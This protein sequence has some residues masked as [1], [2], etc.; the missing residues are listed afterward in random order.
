MSATKLQ[1]KPTEPYQQ[2]IDEVLAAHNTDPGLGFSPSSTRVR[3]SVVHSPDCSL[4]SGCG[5]RCAIV[6]VASG[7]N[8]RT[9]FAAS[10]FDGEFE[11][12]RL[13]A[14]CGCYEL[15]A[16]AARI[17]QDGYTPNG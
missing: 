14:M 1:R 8:L 16:V 15:R 10:V 9:V 12:R 5:V 7:R 2:S 4:T 17:E 3:M 6:A 13:A 11:L